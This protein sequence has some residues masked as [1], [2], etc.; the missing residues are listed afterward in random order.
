MRAMP[1]SAIRSKVPK[2]TGTLA[3]EVPRR[4][5]SAVEREDFLSV[6]RNARDERPLQQYL[7]RHPAFFTSLLP[8]GA[9]LK[10]YDRPR[11][12]SE[13]VPD[14]LACVQNSQGV[15][16]IGLEL[17]SPLA[18]PLTVTGTS[19][20]VLSQ[21]LAQVGDWRDWIG[22]NIAYARN[23]LALKGISGDLEAWV[24]IGRRMDMNSRQRRRYAA[25]KKAGY[26][27]CSFDRLAD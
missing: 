16:W 3:I 2:A 18:A 5:P 8:P 7:A 22:E 19:S 27:V 13:Y 12:G 23:E 6:L 10:M 4:Y 26:H 25:L 14:F 17:E 20:R 24:V 15:H 9:R 11:L 1:R 21:A